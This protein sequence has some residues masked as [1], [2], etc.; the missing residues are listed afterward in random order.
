M[1]ELIKGVLFMDN[2][3]VNNTFYNNI[4]IEKRA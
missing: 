4:E 1:K 3:K 2:Q